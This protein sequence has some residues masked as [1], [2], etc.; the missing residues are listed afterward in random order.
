MAERAENTRCLHDIASEMGYNRKFFKY[1][2]IAAFHFKAGHTAK[3]S[4][5][6]HLSGNKVTKETAD[7]RGLSQGEDETPRLRLRTFTPSNISA[8]LPADCAC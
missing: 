6:G 4:T 3:T 7:V 2:H 1:P 5:G 8:L